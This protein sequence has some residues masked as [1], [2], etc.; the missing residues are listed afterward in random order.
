MDN[1]DDYRD[2]DEQEEVRDPVYGDVP[3]VTTPH[4]RVDTAEIKPTGTGC[5]TLFI[6]I[7]ILGVVLGFI[8]LYKQN[9]LQ[10]Q[11]PPGP[12]VP[13]QTR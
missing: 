12:A 1:H 11:P 7:L 3:S 4:T 8:Y 5:R 6:F 2:D 10:D 13:G 9:Q